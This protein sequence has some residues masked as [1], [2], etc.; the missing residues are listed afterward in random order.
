M[1]CKKILNNTSASTR[2]TSELITARFSNVSKVYTDI[3][4]TIYSCD[5]SGENFL[6]ALQNRSSSF[7]LNDITHLY[8]KAEKLHIHNKILITDSSINPYL[9]PKIE[10]YNI[11]VWN[12]EKLLEVCNQN[13]NYSSSPLKTSNTSDDTCEIDVNSNDPIKENPSFKFNDI[14][15]NNVDHL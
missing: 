6:F 12:K 1:Y 7:S 5:K 4:I 3:Y 9:S 14:F 2:I 10:E 8:E 11:D 15:K 13:S